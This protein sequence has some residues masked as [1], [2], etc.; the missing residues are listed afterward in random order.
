M[1]RSALTKLSRT[2]DDN[3]TVHEFSDAELSA[4]PRR[5]V[6]VVPVESDEERPVDGA[7]N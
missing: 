4:M 6:G 7:L 5:R 1:A 3:R 2:V